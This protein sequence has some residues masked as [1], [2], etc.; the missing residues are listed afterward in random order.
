MYVISWTSCKTERVISQNIS[1]V[2]F[3]IKIY[4]FKNQLQFSRSILIEH[5]EIA[6]HNMFGNRIYWKA[7]RSM[8]FNKELKNI[9]AEFRKIYLNSTD[10]NDNTLLPDDWSQEKVLSL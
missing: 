3:N 2:C 9:A 7:R 10:E 6:L 4:L 5:A 8:R 1:T